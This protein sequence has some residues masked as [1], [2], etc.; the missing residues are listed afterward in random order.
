MFFGTAQK[1][2]YTEC[3]QCYS[4]DIPTDEIATMQ[5]EETPK[6]ITPGMNKK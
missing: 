5:L 3:N 6:K 2:N 4:D 1:R